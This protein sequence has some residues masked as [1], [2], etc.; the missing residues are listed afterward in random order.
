VRFNRYL[1][2]VAVTFGRRDTAAPEE[3][4]D[5]L[6]LLLLSGQFAR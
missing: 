1:V 4:K 6:A 5:T 2:K 3:V